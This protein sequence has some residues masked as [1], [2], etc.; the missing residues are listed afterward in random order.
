MSAYQYRF[1]QVEVS[2]E[3]YA[4]VRI[5]KEPVNSMSLELWSELDRCLH[6]LE[7]VAPH[8]LERAAAAFGHGL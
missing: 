2:P 5:C 1:L 8:S 4:V 6:E 7:A 3:G